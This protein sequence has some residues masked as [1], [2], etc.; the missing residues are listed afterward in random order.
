MQNPTPFKALSVV[1]L[2][3]LDIAVCT[4]IG[5]WIGNKADLWLDTAPIWGIIG[6]FI[7]LGAGILSIIPIVKKYLI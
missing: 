5:Y 4:F 7:G 3:G 6:V 1:S 2:I